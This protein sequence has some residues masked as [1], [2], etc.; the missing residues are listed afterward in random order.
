MSTDTLQRPDPEGLRLPGFGLPLDKM[1]E[2]DE[3]FPVAVLQN[4]WAANTLTIREISMLWFMNQITDKPDWNKKVFDEE[5]VDKWRAE[6]VALEQADSALIEAGF[7]DAMFHW[8][9]QELRDKAKIFERNGMVAIFDAAACAVKSDS[10]VPD[11]LKGALRE[12]VALLENVPD[13]EKDWH[14]GSDEK[15][16]DLVHPSLWPLMYGHS[17][18]V[19]DKLITLEDCLQACGRG[20]LVPAIVGK[21]GNRATGDTNVNSWNFFQARERGP[22]RLWSKKFQWLPCDVELDGAKAKIISY[23]NNLHPVEHAK[24]YPIIE[25]FIEKALPLWDVVYRRTDG[26][27]E[28]SGKGRISCS[29]V[30]RDCKI[31]EICGKSWCSDQN[32]PRDENHHAIQDHPDGENEDDEDWFNRT[33]PVRQPEPGNY[34]FIASDGPVPESGKTHLAQRK[35]IQVIVKLANIHLT[36][37]KPTYDGGS[38]HIEGQLNEHICATALYYYD[39]DNITDSH[40]AF[41]TQ[42]NREDLGMELKY[43]QDDHYCIQNT[44]AIRS[45]EDTL[46]DLGRVLT[47][48]GRLLAFPN[49]YQHRVGP[50]QLADKSRSGHRKILALFLVD[51]EIPVISTAHVPPQQRHWWASRFV[52]D[53]S[54]RMGTLPPEVTD[55][56]IKNVEFPIGIKEAKIVRE[57]LIKERGVLDK[58]V[59]GEIQLAEWSF[60]EH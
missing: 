4:D 51:P 50:F 20:E 33:H 43:E 40:L 46:Q 19:T 34:E 49:V 41:R 3:R 21:A 30:R 29:F 10:I 11:E 24:L 59:M 42:S 15:V 14:P 57:D 58:A 27:K 1:P 45:Q 6:L 23:I 16:L 55:M 17:R 56:V 7:S 26:W 18:I 52:T 25:R 38:W 53:G 32:R 36:P 60:C 28:E 9:V 48:E 13:R 5:I 39:S 8:C 12:A 31:P 35:K 54:S 37:E 2:R 22:L 47:R 44:F